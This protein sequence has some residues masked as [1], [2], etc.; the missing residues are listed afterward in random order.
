MQFTKFKTS[1]QSSGKLSTGIVIP[2]S[3]EMAGY[4]GKQHPHETR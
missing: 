3:V 2:N 4:E 1:N